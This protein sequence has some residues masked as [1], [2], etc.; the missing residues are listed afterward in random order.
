MSLLD[1]V[2][3]NRRARPVHRRALI[4]RD[5]DLVDRE[6]WVLSYQ[7]LARTNL[8]SLRC[9]GKGYSLSNNLINSLSNLCMY[10][11]TIILISVSSKLLYKF[12]WVHFNLLFSTARIC[13]KDTCIG[14]GVR[15]RLG[16][17][18][19]TLTAYRPVRTTTTTVSSYWRP[20]IYFRPYYLEC[21]VWRNDSTLMTIDPAV[22]RVADCSADSALNQRRKPFGVLISRYLGKYTRS[23]CSYI[24][25]RARIFWSFSAWI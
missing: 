23:R 13:C 3:W 1:R 11:R 17:R 10:E 21:E 22:S 4:R 14:W 9:T 2:V 5:P 20:K 25:L 8:P 12:E 15:D 24:T 18:P 6:E 16:S 19:S 7:T